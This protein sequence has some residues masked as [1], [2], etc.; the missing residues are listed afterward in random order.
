MTKKKKKL[1]KNVYILKIVAVRNRKDEI[2]QKK[3]KE[4]Q[5]SF[6]GFLI[7]EI[8]F[9]SRDLILVFTY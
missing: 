4:I 8:Y 2:I 6:L 5:V 1:E 3:E 7:V 9:I